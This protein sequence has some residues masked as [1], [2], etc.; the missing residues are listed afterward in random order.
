RR[1]VG[2]HDTRRPLEEFRG[3]TGS[4]TLLR[5]LVALLLASVSY[6]TTCTTDRVVPTDAMKGGY[7][8]GCA[9]TWS[10]HR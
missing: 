10:E 1:T 9:N 6:T 4:S 3:P 8:P 2:R 7:R 5:A